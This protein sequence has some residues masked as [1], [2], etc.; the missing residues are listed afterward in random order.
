MDWCLLVCLCY[1]FFLYTRYRSRSI[2][3]RRN[4]LFSLPLLS[5][6]AFTFFVF[7]MSVPPSLGFFSEIFILGP[8]FFYY[9]FVSFWLFIIVFFVGVYNIYLFCFLRHGENTLSYFFG[10]LETREHYLFLIHG[11]PCLGLIFFLDFLMFFLV[12]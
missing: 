7:N 4:V 10:D 5:G 1:Y 12:E 9:F 8:L 2:L 6:W 11:L 3:L